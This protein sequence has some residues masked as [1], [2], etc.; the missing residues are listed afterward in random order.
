MKKIIK[1]LC[2]SATLGL[3]SL[4][5]ADKPDLVVSLSSYSKALNTAEEIKNLT[6]PMP[7]NLEQMLLQ[8]LGP[9]ADLSSLDKNKPVLFQVKL[10]VDKKSKPIGAVYI[11]VTNYSNFEKTLSNLVTQSKSRLFKKGQYAVLA[12]KEANDD[13]LELFKSWG[14]TSVAPFKGVINVKL[15]GDYIRNNK[16]KLIAEIKEDAM[17]PKSGKKPTKEELDMVVSLINDFGDSTKNIEFFFENSQKDLSFNFKFNTTP[18]SAF[19]KYLK[20]SSAKKQMTDLSSF[21]LSNELTSYKGYFD[22][23]KAQLDAVGDFYTKIIG[24]SSDEKQSKIIA[25]EGFELLKALQPCEVYGS[26]SADDNLTQCLV[27]KKPNVDKHKFVKHLRS[28]LKATSEM[29]M[30]GKKM[31]KECALKTNTRKS[32]GERVHQ[33]SVKLDK[34]NLKL[35]EAFGSEENKANIL[36]EDQITEFSFVGDYILI[37]MNSE[38]DLNSMIRKA[39]SG[40]LTKKVSLGKDDMRFQIDLAAFNKAI[41]S[42]MDFVKSNPMLQ[43]MMNKPLPLTFAYGYHDEYRM[44]MKLEKLS[45]QTI[46]QAIMMGMMNQ[47]GG[48]GQIQIK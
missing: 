27:I 47:G 31:Y 48:G 41:F 10:P 22:F 23:D 2:I 46:S 30:D 14:P 29:E 19:G 36:L 28:I 32:N 8:N 18:S 21:K 43:M 44:S 11:P 13:D 9:N 5:Y 24:V 7:M 15:N 45:L 25:E 4:I 16:E 42:E 12:P 38:K 35:D 3:S 40:A 1:T 26:M 39:K 6:F 20:S 34:E 17:N 33:V 37:S